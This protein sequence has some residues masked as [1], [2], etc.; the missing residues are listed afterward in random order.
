MIKEK[1][2]LSAK[3]IEKCTEA[4]KSTTPNKREVLTASS[5]VNISQKTDQIV[6]PEVFDLDRVVNIKEKSYYIQNSKLIS[7]FKF[8]FNPE[9]I[10]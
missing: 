3:I 2:K 5:S 1:E 9:L 6:F 7:A 10:N 8:L 4:D